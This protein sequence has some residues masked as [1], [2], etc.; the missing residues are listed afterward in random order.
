MDLLIREL[1]VNDLD[2]S[3]E[4]DDSFIV[5]SRFILSLSKI[6]KR[7]EYTLEGVPSY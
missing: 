7:I 1:D 2:N 5:S 6:N 4:I 3:L